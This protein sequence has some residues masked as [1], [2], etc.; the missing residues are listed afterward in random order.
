MLDLTVQQV[1][2]LARAAEALLSCRRNVPCSRRSAGWPA[3]TLRPADKTVTALLP[4]LLCGD[5]EELRA[6]IEVA[7]RM[8]AGDTRPDGQV[9]SVGSAA[10]DPLMALAHDIVQL[11]LRGEPERAWAEVSQLP[12]PS[13][14]CPVRPGRLSQLPLRRP[15]PLQLAA[16]E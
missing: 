4:D 13:G 2:D 10:H 11:S 3:W 15:R 6:V 5:E 9:I 12:R 14:S 16:A 7:A 8:L 1:T